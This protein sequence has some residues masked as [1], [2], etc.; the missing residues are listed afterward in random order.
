[1][2]KTFAHTTDQTVAQLLGIV[3]GGDDVLLTRDGKPLAVLSKA[4]PTAVAVENMQTFDIP[5]TFY[6]NLPGGY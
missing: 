4:Q 6:E 5:E 3:E 1:M 2:T